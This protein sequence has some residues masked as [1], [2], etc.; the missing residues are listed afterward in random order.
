[1]CRRS[2]KPGCKQYRHR[3]IHLLMVWSGFLHFGYRFPWHQ[4]C[5]FSKCGN[6]P[7]YG[8]GNNNRVYRNTYNHR[9]SKFNTNYNA[10]GRRPG[11]GRG[12]GGRGGGGRGGGGGG[13]F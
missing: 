9:Y 4:Q 12:R 7:C 3:V 2:Y 13:G 10:G 6:L 8:N 5:N 1:M 11:G